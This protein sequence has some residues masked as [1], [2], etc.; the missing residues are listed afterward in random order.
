MQL[1][2][3]LYRANT[4]SCPITGTLLIRTT[5]NKL[6]VFLTGVLTLASIAGTAVAPMVVKAASCADASIPLYGMLKPDGRHFYTTNYQEVQQ[7]A[8]YNY[9]FMGIV[10]RIFA[11]RVSGT[12]AIKR[13]Y[14][15]ATGAHRYFA[16]DSIDTSKGSYEG[17]LGYISTSPSNNLNNIFFQVSDS[18]QDV[19][20]S[21]DDNN[22]WG[23]GLV[24]PDASYNRSGTLGWSCGAQ[25]AITAQVSLLRYYN[26]KTKHHFMTTS[27]TEGNALVKNSGY[28]YEGISG[29]IFAMEEGLNFAAN[30][31]VYRMYKRSSDD[32]LYTTNESEK[33]FLMTQGYTF[34]GTMGWT[35][36]DQGDQGIPMH[37]LFNHT[38]NDRLYTIDN[39]ETQRAI[40]A[41][42]TEES[43]LGYANPRFQYGY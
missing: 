26:P 23:Y 15:S 9:Q 17:E 29:Y 43:P 4:A 8:Q 41:G 24:G 38:T 2:V 32:H 39:L 10:T 25:S 40:A 30:H 16:S 21:I 18:K 14:N 19:I 13:Y 3:C 36:S 35:A 5:M 27:K 37:R 31:P 33:A 34:E 6:K 7:V 42:Y 22:I 11:Q 1:L 20:L 12:V 28:K